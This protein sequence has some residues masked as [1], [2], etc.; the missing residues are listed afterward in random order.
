MFIA[1]CF[2]VTAKVGRRMP[3]N[4]DDM[5]NLYFSW[6][7]TP[8]ELLKANLTFTTGGVEPLKPCSTGLNSRCGV[9]VRSRSMVRCG[10]FWR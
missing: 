1:G 6:I 4:D 10:Q 8:W 2:I 3:Y 9:F 5:M 7:M